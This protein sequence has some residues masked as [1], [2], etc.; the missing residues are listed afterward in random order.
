MAANIFHDDFLQIQQRDVGLQM[1]LQAGQ[2][3][4]P[5]RQCAQVSQ[6]DTVA[7]H[8]LELPRDSFFFVWTQYSKNGTGLERCRSAKVL[9]TFLAAL[10][11]NRR[12]FPT[13]SIG[14]LAGFE[15][16]GNLNLGLAEFTLV[17]DLERQQL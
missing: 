17:A 13:D 7:F 6:L 16:G 10:L 1:R 15:H 5:N 11:L 14:S 3:E 4:E 2:I 12:L 8:L 9:P